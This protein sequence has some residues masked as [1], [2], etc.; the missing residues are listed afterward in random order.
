V[1]L[2]RDDFNIEIANR[3]QEILQAS[4]HGLEISYTILFSDSILARLHY[5]VRLDPRSQHCYDL[6]A[7]ENQLIAVG[8]SWQDG[9]R[10]NLA[11]RIGEEEGNAMMVRYKRAFSLSYQE[12][13]SPAQAIFDIE[14][15]E[16]LVDPQQLETNI[17]YPEGK[18]SGIIRFKLF[19]LHSTVAL[20]DAIPILEK[21]GFRVLGE[22]PYKI[23]AK[24]KAP[25]WINDFMMILAH[26]QPLPLDEIQEILRETFIRVWS[27]KAEHDGFNAL[28][29]SACIPWRQIA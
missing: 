15:A 12:N 25:V 24:P 23:H 29:L 26:E 13:F 16:T 6:E 10:E 19:H 21:M 17:Y 20:S 1:Y 18:A 7:I 4:F 14:K 2:P 3:M 22:Q 11:K 27:G 8:R 28:A 9:L 5:T